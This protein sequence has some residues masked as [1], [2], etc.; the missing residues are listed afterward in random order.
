MT[1]ERQPKQKLTAPLAYQAYLI[2]IWQ[3]GQQAPWRASA[4][5]VQSGE[6]KR[7]ASLMALFAFLE[8]QTKSQADG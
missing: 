5:E 7:F 1:S 3:D 6:V 2:R 8:A 4:Q